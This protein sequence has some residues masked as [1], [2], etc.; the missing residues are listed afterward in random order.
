MKETFGQ[1]FTRLRRAKELRQE[2]IADKI[3]ISPQAVSK[4]ENDISLP[5]ITILGELSDILGVTLD[6][7]LG[8]EKPVTSVVFNEE[9]KD[10]KKM[11]LKIVVD[12]KNGDRVR[13]NLPMALVKL[14]LETGMTFPDVSGNQALKNIDFKQVFDLVEQ[15]LMGE[16][17]TVDSE[18]GDHIVILVE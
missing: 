8:K 5:D 2:D 16:L 7:L 9:K 10:I 1:R 3:G 4:W 18:D 17:I 14:G 12:G 6:E 11:M 13:V 15:G